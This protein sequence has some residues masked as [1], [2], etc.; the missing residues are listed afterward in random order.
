MRITSFTIFNQITRSLSDNLRNMARLS[1]MLASGKKI[2]NPSDDVSGMTKGMDYKVSISEIEQYKRNIDEANA[3]LSFA[4]TNMSSVTNSLTRARELAVQASTGSLSYL[5]RVAIAKEI[6]ELRDEIQSLANTKFRNRYTFSGFMTDTQSFDAGFNYQGDSGE[7]NV[8]ID[9]NATIAINIPGDTVF[10]SGATSIM[11]SLNSL[12]NALM[13][14]DPLVAQA[15]AQTAIT[16]IDN[17]IDQIAN[18]RADIGAR[19]NHLDNS[20]SNLESRDTTLKTFL[21]EI[22]DTDIADTVT[23]IS[24]T[25]LALQSLRQSGAKILSQSLLDFLQ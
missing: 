6:A 7:I 24:K 19:Q 17:A 22:E 13:D 25:E 12:Y 18:A 16:D 1:N 21:S 11:G 9:R 14:P 2:N 8:L 10:G 20:R 4:E 23:E 3:H 5:D 15:G